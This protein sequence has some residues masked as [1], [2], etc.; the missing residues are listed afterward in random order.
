M[1]TSTLRPGLLVSLKTAIRGNVSYQHRDIEPEHLTENGQQLAKWETERAI[2][3]PAEF[4]AATK[5]RNKIR[6]FISSACVRSAFGLLCPEKS[7][8]NLDAALAEATRLADEFNAAAK[9]TRINVY[10][11]AGR[12]APDDLEAMR[13]INSEARDLL[14]TMAEGIQ[15]LD[16]AAVR[17][18]A[19]RARDIGRMLS[20]DAQARIGAAIETARSAA[21]KIVKAGEQAAQEIDQRTIQRITEART[22]FLDLDKAVEVEAPAE[23]AR[24]LDFEPTPDIESVTAPRMPLEFE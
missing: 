12:I 21:R 14:A 2:A 8:D 18:A 17:D 10:V 13:A 16:V 24:A 19:D 4:E 1:Q 9:L 7:A 15:N 20:P 22:A 23:E 3:D 11:I 6:T 5:I